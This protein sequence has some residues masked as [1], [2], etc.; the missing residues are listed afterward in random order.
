MPWSATR[1]LLFAL[2]ALAIVGA[3]AVGGYFSFFYEAPSCFDGRQNQG[4]EGVDCGGACALLCTQP[5]ISTVWARTVRAAPGVYH[6]VALVRNPDTGAA[7][8]VPYEVSLFDNENLLIARREGELAIGPGDIIP[9]FEANVITGE[10]VPTRTFVEFAAGVF[11]RAERE[12]TPIRVVSFE[13]DEDAHRLTAEV[14]NRSSLPAEDITITALLFDDADILVQASQT[15]VA[16]LAT[17]ERRSIVF[18][19]QEPF[20]ATPKRV[21]IIPRAAQ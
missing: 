10:R 6:A 13:L 4:E 21:D 18:T 19:W 12:A 5:N 8:S 20:P 7:G 1:Q 3:L 14:E 9:L 17:R 11:T 15:R 16:S 2:G